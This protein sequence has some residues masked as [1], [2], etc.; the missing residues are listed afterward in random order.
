MTTEGSVLATAKP[1]FVQTARHRNS[2]E[3]KKIRFR[4][5]LVKRNAPVTGRLTVECE[6]AHREEPHQPH[7]EYGLLCECRDLIGDGIEVHDGQTGWKVELMRAQESRMK[8][9]ET[10]PHDDSESFEIA[11]GRQLT[12]FQFTP[13]A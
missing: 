4:I 6:D 1:M 3:T 13:P 7:P 2:E 10:T 9:D 11:C 8:A 12:S 5:Q